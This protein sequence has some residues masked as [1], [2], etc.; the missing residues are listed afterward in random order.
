MGVFTQLACD[1]KGVAR[2]FAQFCLCVL[3]ALAFPYLDVA[4]WDHRIGM[5]SVDVGSVAVTETQSN[6]GCSVR[7]GLVS[8]SVKCGLCS[9]T[10]EIMRLTK[11][12]RMEK[13]IG[14]CQ[15]L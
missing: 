6:V 1:I 11:L 9:C 2:K 10:S 14:R 12:P 8:S 3:W 15:S 13:L 7:A 5:A 4:S